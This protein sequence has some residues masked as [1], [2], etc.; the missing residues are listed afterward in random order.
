MQLDPGVG[1]AGCEEIDDSQHV[2]VVVAGH[3]REPHP[4]RQEGR[5]RIHQVGCL[6]HAGMTMPTDRLE[7]RRE[8]RGTGHEATARAAASR[9]PESGQA[10]TPMKP[11]TA[12][13][14]ISGVATQRGG[15]AGRCDE[16]GGPRSM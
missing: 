14:P 12:K 16:L 9:R 5:G 2:T 7:R 11:Q 15:G 8:D 13:P 1:R 4:L 3:E 10:N 6:H